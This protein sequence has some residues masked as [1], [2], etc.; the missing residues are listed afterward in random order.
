MQQD[1]FIVGIGASAGALPAMIGFFQHIPE[2]IN[3]AFVVIPHLMRERRS[4][5]DEILSKH[6]TLPV[7]RVVNDTPIEPGH[8]YLLVEGTYLTSQS[9]ILVP[10]PREEGGINHAADIFLESLARDAGN[11]S[12]AI[13]LSGG[14]N[15]G[16]EGAKAV[17]A[18]NGR[19]LVQDPESSQVDGMPLSII[20]FDHPHKVLVP[21]ALAKEVQ[22]IASPRNLK[23]SS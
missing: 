2:D 1:F 12:I 21:A 22:E 19:V 8:I 18:A 20:L 10:Q 13:I 23:S 15:D 14:G 6:A 5:L 3:A 11:C 16:L 9:R 7:V 17:N 4:Y